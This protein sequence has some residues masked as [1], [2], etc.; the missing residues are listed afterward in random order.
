MIVAGPHLSSEVRQRFQVEAQTIARLHHPNIVQIY[1]VGEHA[2]CPF[3][4]LELMEGGTLAERIAG[5]PQPAREAA[6]ILLTLTK[7]VEYAHRQGVVHRDLKPANVLLNVVPDRPTKRE[8]KITDF[9]IAKVLP[10]SR[11][12]PSPDDANR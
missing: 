12:G 4:S 8:L 1:D 10:R 2:K 7:A 3:L 9:G 5:K 6:R 11:H